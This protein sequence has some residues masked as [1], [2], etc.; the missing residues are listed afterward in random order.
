MRTRTLLALGVTIV[1]VVGGAAFSTVASGG[2]GAAG[3]HGRIPI[4][5]GALNRAPRTVPPHR[6]VSSQPGVQMAVTSFTGVPVTVSCA[7]CHTTMPANRQL[8][9]GGQMPVKFHQGLHYSHGGQSCLSCHNADNYDT[10]RLADG[11][12]VPFSQAQQLCG[13]C[14]GPQTRDYLNGSHG[15]MTGYWDLSRGDRVRNTCTDCHDPHVPAYSVVQ[16]VFAPRDR[17]ARQQAL[18]AGASAGTATQH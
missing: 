16:P 3:A 9:S 4:A 2:P 1:A 12:S 15:G 5:T 6:P 14:H 11:R 13:Q 18:R 7:T 8:G 17:G 10:L